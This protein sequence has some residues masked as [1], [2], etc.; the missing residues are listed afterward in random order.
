MPHPT[1][2]QITAARERAQRIRDYAI[3]FRRELQLERIAEIQPATEESKDVRRSV[4]KLPNRTSKRE[5]A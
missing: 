2:K 5:A 1:V 3:A 4:V